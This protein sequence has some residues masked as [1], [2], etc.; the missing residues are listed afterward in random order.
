MKTIIITI[1]SALVLSAGIA[2]TTNN[3]AEKNEAVTVLKEIN[4][5]SKIEVRGNVELY[6]TDGAND[7]VKVY[8]KYYNESALVQGTNG[9]L[10]IASYKAEKLV[11]WVTAADLRSVAVYDNSEVKS[12]GDISKIEFNVYLYNTASAKLSL[13]SFIANVVVND[14]AKANLSGTVNE[15]SLKYNH[16]ENIDYRNLES[17]QSFVTN[18]AASAMVKQTRK[19]ELADL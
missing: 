10:R 4:N 17:K 19:D 8:N 15:I 5:I 6:I 1:F 13:N 16:A 7:Q 2:K 9:V 12:F 18:V 14:E 3:P 11:V